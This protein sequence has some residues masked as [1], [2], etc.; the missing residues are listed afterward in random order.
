M[1]QWRCMP[2]LHLFFTEVRSFLA[3]INHDSFQRMKEYFLNY[4]WVVLTIWQ[5]QTWNILTLIFINI[6]AITFLNLETTN[7]KFKPCFVAFDN[8]HGVN[9]S[10][11]AGFKLPTHLL[12]QSWEEIGSITPVNS[13]STYRYN[14]HNLSYQRS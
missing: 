1:K 9:T 2:E 8:F 3:E 13:I 7:N 6:F 11:M 14:Q 4:G 5:P 10:T 12:K